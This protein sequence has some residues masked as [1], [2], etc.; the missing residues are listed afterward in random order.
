MKSMKREPSKVGL[1]I[2][3]EREERGWSLQELSDRSGRLPQTIDAIELGTSRRP[4]IET[5]LPIT[6]ALSIDRA[7]VLGLMTPTPPE[8][9]DAPR[10]TGRN[11]RT[12]MASGTTAKS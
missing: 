12:R 9:E 7:E 11:G 1:R 10:Q 4:Q 6:D 3:A 5:V 8:E 2:K